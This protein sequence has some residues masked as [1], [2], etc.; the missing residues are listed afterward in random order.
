MASAYAHIA[1]CIDGSPAGAAAL[2]SALALWREAG[3][4]LSLVHAGPYPLV[5]EEIDG[6]TVFRREDL[7]AS[8]RDWLRRRARDIPG[9]EPVFVQGVR[10]PATCAWAEGAGADL[11]V[12]GAGSGR[13]PGLAPGGFVHHLL[14]RAP[15]PVLVVR[16]RAC[17]CSGGCACA[18]RAATA[19]APR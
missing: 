2:E 11:I 15:C 7:N 3:G 9:A 14:E 18:E 19:P 1:C 12:V 16:P 17:A 8:A 4:R 10:G 6:E 5:I 13:S